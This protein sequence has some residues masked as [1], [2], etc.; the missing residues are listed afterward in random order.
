MGVHNVEGKG[1]SKPKPK[2]APNCALMEIA[3]DNAVVNYCTCKV[4]A[5]KPAHTTKQRKADKRTG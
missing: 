3:R 4:K 5:P 2:H 1:M